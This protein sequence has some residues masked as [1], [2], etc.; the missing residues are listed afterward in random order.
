MLC[1]FFCPQILLIPVICPRAHKRAHQVKDFLPTQS[2][3]SLQGKRYIR[4][5]HMVK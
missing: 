2:E 3:R 1:P 5:H 4:L